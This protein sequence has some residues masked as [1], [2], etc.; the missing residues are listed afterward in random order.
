MNVETVGYKF[1]LTLFLEKRI[2]TVASL[3][4]LR[5]MSKEVAERFSPGWGAFVT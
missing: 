3:N 1:L 2:S 5:R 4:V